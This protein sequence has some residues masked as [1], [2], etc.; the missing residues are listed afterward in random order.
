M[1]RDK[2]AGARRA[3]FLMALAMQA[4]LAAILLLLMLFSLGNRQG[5]LFL[6]ATLLIPL[7]WGALWWRAYA[8]GEAA[9]RE[10]RWTREWEARETR[11]TF[12]L[13]GAVLALWGVLVALVV[14]LG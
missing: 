9:R 4:G 3:R 12:G 13:M 6:A 14:W 11:R 1:A 10:G 2:G 5:L 8:G 7:G